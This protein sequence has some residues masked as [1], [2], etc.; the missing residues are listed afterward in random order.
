MPNESRYT[1][2]PPPPPQQDAEETELNAKVGIHDI[3][4]HI[5]EC[6]RTAFLKN[7]N[8]NK[9]YTDPKQCC[10]PEIAETHLDP[11][12]FDLSYSRLMFFYDQNLIKF[13]FEKFQ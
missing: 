4:S 10:E 1:P 9:A 2:L 12:F 8:Q 13:T 3:S 6:T 7:T 5:H 11:G